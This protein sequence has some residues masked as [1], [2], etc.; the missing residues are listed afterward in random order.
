MPQC[1]RIYHVSV[2]SGFI[3]HCGGGGDRTIHLV[4]CLLCIYVFTKYIHIISTDQEIMHSSQL[5]SFLMAY[6][7]AKLKSNCDKSSLVS[8]HSEKET[9]PIDL[10]LCGLYYRSHLS[11]F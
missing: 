11:T 9:H 10:Y 6:S 7:K 8:N 4:L 5:Q 2:N 1:Q 3:L